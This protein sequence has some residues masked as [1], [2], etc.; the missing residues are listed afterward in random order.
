MPW[1]T[2]LQ[3]VHLNIASYAGSPLRVVAGPE[4]GLCYNSMRK[5]CDLLERP[6]KWQVTKPPVMMSPTQPNAT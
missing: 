4:T 6:Q 1:N 3:G 5:V 2:G